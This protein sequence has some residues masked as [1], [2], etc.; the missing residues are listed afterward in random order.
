MKTN[1]K[2]VSALGVLRDTSHVLLT[3][4]YSKMKS[5]VDTESV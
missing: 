2:I 4:L 1:K 5:I 3:G